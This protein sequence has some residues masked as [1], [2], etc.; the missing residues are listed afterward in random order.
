MDLTE[1]KFV[2][3]LETQLSEID[4]L[5]SVFYKQGELRINDMT[6]LNQIKQYVDG[7]TRQQ[8]SCLDVTINVDVD[9]T[10]YEVCVTFPHTYPE[11]PP[12]IF[13]RNNKLNKIQ[14][15]NLNKDISAHINT[16]KGDPCVFSAVSWLQD[17]ASNYTNLNERVQEEKTVEE[18]EELIRLWIYS[19]HIYNKSK[20][21]EILNLAN[22]LKVTG[23]CMPGK[24]GI[25]CIEGNKRDCLEYWQTIKSLTWKKIYCK[26]T[27]EHNGKEKD[28]LKF[29]SFEEVVFPN[30]NVKCNH[31]DMGEL[32]IFL[33][34]HQCGHIFKELFG[35]DNKSN[36][37]L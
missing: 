37:N 34:G 32:H 4:T 26:F 18:P 27:E 20:R 16:L 31:M 25:I 33:E 1:E 28:F 30:S 2:H 6:V 29:K 5:Q 9:D 3:N 12:E 7:S 10:K 21:R 11:I 14:H 17:N 36:N 24:P 23:F 35:V 8:P 19:H 13:V 15:T 22:D